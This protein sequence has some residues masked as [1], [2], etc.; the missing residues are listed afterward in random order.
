MN[1]TLKFEIGK[2]MFF[3]ENKGYILTNKDKI[4]IGDWYY[5]TLISKYA[6][7]GP[8]Q[9]CSNSLE[10]TDLIK[11]VSG[12]ISHI[13]FVYK[14]IATDTNFKIKGIPQFESDKNL[15][16]NVIKNKY[17]DPSMLLE[18]TVFRKGYN[19]AKDKYGYTLED[20]KNAFKAGV[21]S[22]RNNFDTYTE[23]NNILNEQKY[24]KTIIASKLIYGI[25]V[26]KENNNLNYPMMSFSNEYPN[27]LIEVKD[28][29]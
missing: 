19:F 22:G 18:R 13:D 11:S 4:N 29:F 7:V 14:I 27:G 10:E 16:N 17:S 9:M 3:I 12:N 1:N 26:E 21:N 28:I 20:I 8:L 25:E 15:L 2:N 24:I 23:S 5:D 6:S